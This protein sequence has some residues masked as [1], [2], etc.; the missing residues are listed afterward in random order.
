MKKRPVLGSAATDVPLQVVD[1]CQALVNGRLLWQSLLRRGSELVGTRGVFGLPLE[2]LQQSH[3]R[4]YER[5]FLGSR[6]TLHLELAFQ[7]APE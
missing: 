2:G 6:P 7:R 5:F 3:V 1:G 4:G